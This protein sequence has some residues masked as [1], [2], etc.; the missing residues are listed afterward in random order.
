MR[1]EASHPRDIIFD[2]VWDEISTSEDVE[3]LYALYGF[4]CKYVVSNKCR[5]LNM[6]NGRELT[7]VPKKDANGKPTGYY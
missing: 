7:P 5:V 6:S 4:D 3:P 2:P 1:Y